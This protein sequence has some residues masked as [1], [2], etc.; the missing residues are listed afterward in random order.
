MAVLTAIMFLSFKQDDYFVTPSYVLAKLYTNN[1]LMIFNSRLSI[2]EGRNGWPS[3]D[4]SV[5]YAIPST[6]SSLGSS[7][8]SSNVQTDEKFCRECRRLMHSESRFV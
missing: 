6:S 7:E 1:L 8:I 3:E 2:E 4:R 5:S